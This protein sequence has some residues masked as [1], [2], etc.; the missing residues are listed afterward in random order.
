ML[1]LGLNFFPE[2]TGISPYTSAMAR[3]VFRS[4]L[5][6]RVLTAHPHYPDWRIREGY[7]QWSRD[8]VVNDVQVRRLLHYVPGRPKGARRLLSELTFGARLVLSRWGSPDVIVAVSPALFSTAVAAVRA[9]L[10]RRRVPFVVW[11]QDLYALGLSET[12]QGGGATL[13]LIRAVEGALLRRATRVVV[14]HDRFAARVR[15]DFAVDPQRIEVIR[16]WTHLAPAPDIDVPAA[17]ARFGWHEDE[18]V[19]LHAG[20]MG[21]KQGL[22]NVV[23]AARLAAKRGERVRFVLLGD[24]SE[25]GRLR[26]WAGDLPTIEFIPPLDDA[27]FAQALAAA[28]VLLVNEL[29]GVAEMAVPS[30]LTSYFSVGRPVLAATDLAGITAEEVRAADAG[31][32]VPAGDPAALLDGVIALR[33]DAENAARLGRN[34]RKYRDT[35]LDEG[36]AISRW[37]A[38]INSVALSNTHPSRPA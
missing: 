26:A 20:N 7:G 35:V 8:E 2:P 18:T 4:G 21:V 6:T 13:R 33:A 29:P 27:S 19:V 10:S 12:G 24:G 17:R 22:D 15:D 25:K 16:N 32:V 38:L 36:H 37:V 11:V 3:G 34:G 1:V 9:K 28:D 30:K 23:D 31:A 5:P 14:I